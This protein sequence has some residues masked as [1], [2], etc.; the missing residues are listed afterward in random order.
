LLVSITDGYSTDDITDNLN[1]IL[2]L[3]NMLLFA[4]A[5][6]ADNNM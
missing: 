5:V 2:S 6:N 1:R 3:D 4:A